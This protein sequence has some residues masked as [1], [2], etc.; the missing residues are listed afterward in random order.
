MEAKLDIAKDFEYIKTQVF[1]LENFSKKV[2]IECRN[3]FGSKN[4]WSGI[5]LDAPIYPHIDKWVSNYQKLHSHIWQQSYEP[6]VM[7]LV[8]TLHEIKF[9]KP[10]LTSEDLK[11][12]PV[13]KKVLYFLLPPFRWNINKKKVKEVKAKL[14]EFKQTIEN[15][16]KFVIRLEGH[17]F[18]S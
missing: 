15:A 18:Y 17:Y 6:E 16:K 7:E 13:W 8:A 12:F 10:S 5:P 9:A 3:Y 14:N 4:Y 1:Y 2:E 11:S